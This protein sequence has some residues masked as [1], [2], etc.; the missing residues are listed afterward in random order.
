MNKKLNQS[1]NS[2]K[3]ASHVSPEKRLKKFQCK[4]N[5]KSLFKEE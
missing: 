3:R 4:R 1:R 5:K 2:V